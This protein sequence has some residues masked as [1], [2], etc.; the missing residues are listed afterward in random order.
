MLY[1][2]SKSKLSKSYL[3]SYLSTPLPTPIFGSIKGSGFLWKL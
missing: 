3:Q 2:H 1:G